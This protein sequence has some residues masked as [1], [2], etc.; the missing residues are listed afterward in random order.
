MIQIFKPYKQSKVSNSKT[1][2]AKRLHIRD[3]PQILIRHGFYSKFIPCVLP[4][5]HEHSLLHL[6]F[7]PW[8]PCIV[9]IINLH[10]SCFYQAQID[11]VANSMVKFHASKKETVIR[12]DQMTHCLIVFMTWLGALERVSNKK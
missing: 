6:D 11:R 5:E 7:N 12:K 10:D 1:P 3:Y 4:P 8:Q 9:T 2:L